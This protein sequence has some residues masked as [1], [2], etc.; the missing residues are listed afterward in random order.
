MQIIKDSLI[1][2]S[3]QL[4]RFITNNRLSLIS[5][6]MKRLLILV[7]VVAV[8]YKRVQF[9]SITIPFDV[10]FGKNVMI[11]IT[12]SGIKFTLDWKG[13]LSK[14]SLLIQ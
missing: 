11:R 12:S 2:T 7:F 1:V 8:Y 9:V 13:L 10:K 4:A 3:L 5:E 6:Q 14:L